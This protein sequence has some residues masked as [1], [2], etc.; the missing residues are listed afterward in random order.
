MK[1][2]AVI[3]SG[4]LAQSVVNS[5]A[6]I[7]A[8]PISVHL[9]ARSTERVSTM[10]HVATCRAALLGSSMSVTP[11]RMN[12]DRPGDSVAALVDTV[13]PHV[14]L[15]CS[16]THSSAEAADHP[17]AWT[18]VVRACGI[19]VALPL[20]VQFAALMSEAVMRSGKSDTKFINA[21]YPDAV[22]PVLAAL[23]LPVFCGVGNIATLAATLTAAAV[24]SGDME[25]PRI[26]AHHYH[27]AQPEHRQDE[28]R[29]WMGADEVTD[30]R[31]R[32]A[33]LRSCDRRIRNY[34][35]GHTAALL[36]RDLLSDAP[37]R[38]HVPGPLGLPGGF[39]V[40]V[41]QG[42]IALDLP[43]GLN[44]AQAV[45]QQVQWGG[46]NGVAV[47][48]QGRAQF[49]DHLREVVGPYLKIPR[50]ME[51]AE[52]NLLAVELDTVRQRLRRQES[53]RA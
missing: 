47:D 15:N 26:L 37:F 28:A 43:D 3:G 40:R 25:R 50:S 32:L 39:P 27:L 22:N 29:I 8:G 51:P 36:I 42:H 48:G 17:S 10:A 6:D 13:R 30:A 45:A 24:G 21:A 34:L 1:T 14:A 35:T 11:H 46:K 7:E 9:I 16:S 52:I 44:E 19:A 41:E 18:D 5:F 12:P 53:S 38:T 20:H 49:S 4:S 2:V 31:D 23:G 33:P